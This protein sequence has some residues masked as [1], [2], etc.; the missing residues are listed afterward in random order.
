MMQQI[1]QL[2]IILC[3]QENRMVSEEQ[4]ITNFHAMTIAFAHRRIFALIYKQ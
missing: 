3:V 2:Q 1:L 4:N